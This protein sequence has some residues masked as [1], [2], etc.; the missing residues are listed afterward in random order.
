[1]QKLYHLASGCF[2]SVTKVVL[3]EVRG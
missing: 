2:R 1:M 3:F